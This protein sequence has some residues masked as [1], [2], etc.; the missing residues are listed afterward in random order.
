MRVGV[1][2]LPPGSADGETRGNCTRIRGSHGRKEGRKRG[3][4]ENA[5]RIQMQMSLMPEPRLAV[6]R[7]QN[8]AAKANG[9]FANEQPL[10]NEDEICHA[11]SRHIARLSRTHALLFFQGRYG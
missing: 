7:L 11:L 6:V 4:N 1:V 5:R 3:W 8:I 2:V 9:D 10:V